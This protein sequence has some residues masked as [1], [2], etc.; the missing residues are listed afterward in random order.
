MM[1]PALSRQARRAID[2][3]LERMVLEDDAEL[4]SQ[5]DRYIFKFFVRISG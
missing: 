2:K 4:E 3:Y 1:F 5:D